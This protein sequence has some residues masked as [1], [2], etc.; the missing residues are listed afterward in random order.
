VRDCLEGS[1]TP[2]AI[3]ELLGL[4][5]RFEQLDGNGVRRMLAL[6]CRE[7]VAPCC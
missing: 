5:R 4:G 7:D 6:A 2:S 1:L 3:D